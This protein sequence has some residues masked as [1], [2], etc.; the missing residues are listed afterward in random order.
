MTVHSGAVSH[1]KKEEAN[2]LEQL[3]KKYIIN[4]YNQGAFDN[5]GIAK[6]ILRDEGK[7]FTTYNSAEEY[8]NDI[9]LQE[10]TKG[11]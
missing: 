11:K 6:A 10:K 3:T 7:E 9:Y 8:F 5:S 2:Q 1:D 4:A